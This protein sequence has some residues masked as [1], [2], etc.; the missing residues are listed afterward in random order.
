MITFLN[1]SFIFLMSH[2]TC[3]NSIHY[4]LKTHENPVNLFML[5]PWEFKRILMLFH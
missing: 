2:S 1:F 3:S 4:K 5:N